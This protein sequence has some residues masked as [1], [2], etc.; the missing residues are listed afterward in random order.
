MALSY[1]YKK[2]VQRGFPITGQYKR[3]R[4][5]VDDYHRYTFRLQNPDGSFSTNWL[6]R[7]T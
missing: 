2:R 4:K 6:M 1:A 3:A 5:Y 7:S